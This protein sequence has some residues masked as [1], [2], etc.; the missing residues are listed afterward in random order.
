MDTYDVVIV[1]GRVAGRRSQASWAPAASRSCCE[2]ATFSDTL[3]THV[4]YGDSFGIWE[5][6]GAWPAIERLGS[7][8]LG[9]SH[10]FEDCLT[11]AVGSGRSG[12]TTIL[13]IRR[14]LLDVRLQQRGRNPWRDRDPGGG[15]SPTSCT[16]GNG[17]RGSGSRRTMPPE[18]RRSRPRRHV[19]WSDATV[20]DRS[21]QG[22]WMLVSTSPSRRSISPSTRTSKASTPGPIPSRCSRSGRAKPIGGTPMLAECD[23]GIS[24]AIVYLPQHFDAFRIGKDEN[25]WKAMDS[26]PRLGPRLRA[27]TVAPIRGAG[28]FVN[29]IR[30]PVVRAGCWW[31]MRGNSKIRSSVRESVTR[32]DRPSPWP[33]AGG[34]RRD[35]TGLASRGSRS[36]ATSTSCRTSSG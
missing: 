6:I 16:M 13:C 7:Q 5:R 15:A 4:I 17:L 18:D 9:G 27:G 31:E 28:D 34:E 2:R 33:T 3:S 29:F 30:E 19:W 32:C 12:D 14:V 25:F 24:M 8:K 10:G 21:S 11:S 1:G 20:A 36:R 35:P 22:L 26:D 23:A